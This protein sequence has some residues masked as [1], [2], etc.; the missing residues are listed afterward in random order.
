[1]C[2]ALR[3]HYAFAPLLLNEQCAAAAAAAALAAAAAPA[4][5]CPRCIYLAAGWTTRAPAQGLCPCCNCLRMRMRMHK[6]FLLLLLL[7]PMLQ[8]QC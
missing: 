2:Q 6:E 7:S 3:V 8:L 5:A 1:V 4:I